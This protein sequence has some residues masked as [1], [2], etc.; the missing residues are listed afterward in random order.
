MRK[1]CD[2]FF[3][4]WRRGWVVR[5]GVLQRYHVRLSFWI[6]KNYVC[7]VLAAGLRHGNTICARL[8]SSSTAP[9]NSDK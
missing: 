1:L 5:D 7:S 8:A 2:F 4:G 6:V 9:I 3:L